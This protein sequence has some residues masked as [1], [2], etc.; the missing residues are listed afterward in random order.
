MSY[1]I[2]VRIW[3]PCVVLLGLTGGSLAQAEDWPQWRGPRLDGTSTETNL[4]EVWAKNK[5]VVWRTPLPG[6]AGSTP[7]IVGNRIFLTSARDPDLLLLCLDTSGK[8]LWERKVTSGDQTVRGDEGNYASPSP[9][10]DGKHVW[11]MFGNGILTAFDFDG[12]EVWRVDLQQVYGKFSIQF[13]MASTPVLD[14]DRLY[15]QLLNSNYALVL[16][17]DKATGKEIWRQKR[18]S[19]AR[20]ECEHS[21]ASPTL[22]HSGNEKYLLTHGGDYIVAH[23]L[24]DGSEIWRCGGLNSKAG[25]YNPTLR[26]VAS[27]VAAPGLIV[28]PSA[29]NGPVLGIDPAAQGNITK[30]A[31]WHLWSRADNTPDVPSPL[32]HDG[33]VYLCRENGVLLCLDAKTGEQLYMER[34]HS[35]RHRASP[36]Y[37][38]GKLYLT[39]R[40]G[41]VTVVQAGRSFKILASND[42]GEAVSSSPAISGSRIYLRSYDALYAIA[43]TNNVALAEPP[44][45]AETPIFNGRDLSG[46]VVEGTKE[47]KDDSKHTPIWSA[48][49]GS[50]HCAGSGYGF[51]R[52]DRQLTDFRFS[53]EYQMSKGCNSGIGIRGTKF[54]GPAETRPS[55]YGYEIQI[56][57]DAG[58]KPDDHSSGSLYRYLAATANPVKPA[59]EWNTMEV[60]CIGP[61]IRISINGQPVQDVDQSKVPA[62]A[63]KPVAGYLSLQNHGKR[64]EFRAL[65]LVELP[66]ASQTAAAV[67]PA[68]RP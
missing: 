33:L 49:D 13:G 65:R 15:L 57:D 16:A 43:N 36:V 11:C 1:S 19:D 21:Y 5:N 67:A 68:G 60:E 66:A 31:R 14:G 58:K 27:P 64:I 10:S 54:T 62:L 47:I 46:W 18:E 17:L 29:K 61:R 23:R 7:V 12:H 51:L 35:H 24:S 40:D 3:F 37:A 20:D 52:L 50:I 28:V 48:A 45:V 2:R 25:K 59:G 22:Y 9:M 39:A 30:E 6:P 53:V 4:P 38:D 63:A 56:L 41:V 34:C 26:F 32:V 42:L 8:Q 55:F 44:A